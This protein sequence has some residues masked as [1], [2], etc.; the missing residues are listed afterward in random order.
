MFKDLLNWAGMAWL[1]PGPRHAILVNFIDL[2][3]FNMAWPWLTAEGKPESN[4][5]A[6][7]KLALAFG[8]IGLS[9]KPRR[10]S[11][12]NEFNKVSELNSGLA[13]A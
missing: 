7:L 10:A 6:P 5:S 3:N 8:W 9:L 12:V 13:L 1:R 11:D 4:C 2:L